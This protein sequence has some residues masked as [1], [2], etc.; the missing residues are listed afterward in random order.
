MR[1]AVILSLSGLAAAASSGPTYFSSSSR[2]HQKNL[3][4]LGPFANI[5]STSYAAAT[6]PSGQVPCDDGCS[7]AGSTCCSSGDG[8][9]C[10]DGYYC[11]DEGCCEDGDVCSG[12]PVGCTEGADMCGQYCVPEGGDCCDTLSGEYCPSGQSCNGDGTCSLGSGG[13]NNNGDDDDD[14]DG[15]SLCD[16][17]QETCGTSGC[18]P[19]GSVCCGGIGYYCESGSVCENDGTCSLGSGSDDDDDSSDDDDDSSL[20]SPTYS[21]TPVPTSGSDEDDSSSNDDSSDDNNND[22]NDNSSDDN[23]NNSSGDDEDS[24]AALLNPKVLIALAAMVPAL[25]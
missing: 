15:G 1:S 24:A 2:G 6:C 12:P 19:S 5:P 13:G 23:N 14:S 17:G 8:T 18:M 10:P 4:P 25:L 22:S 7:E 16:K 20:P 9:Y 3:L 21:L 11:Y